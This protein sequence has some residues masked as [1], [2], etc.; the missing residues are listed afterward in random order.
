[1][2]AMFGTFTEQLTEVGHRPEMKEEGPSVI[3]APSLIDFQLTR[4]IPDFDDFVSIPLFVKVENPIGNGLEAFMDFQTRLNDEVDSG[5]SVQLRFLGVGEESKDELPLDAEF[6]RFWYGVT[7]ICNYK[8]KV[9][10]YGK[11]C[12]SIRH[13]GVHISGSPRNVVVDPGCAF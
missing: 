4:L 3:L 1:M 10:R 9:S 5:L 7:L 13:R 2:P 12:I 8:V 6:N 11:Y